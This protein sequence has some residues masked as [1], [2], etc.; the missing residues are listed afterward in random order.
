MREGEP[1]DLA[2]GSSL[3]CLLERREERAKVLPYPEI[4]EVV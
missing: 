4:D 1:S 2:R 3:S